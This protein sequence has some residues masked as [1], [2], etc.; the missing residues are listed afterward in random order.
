[1]LKSGFII[2]YSNIKVQPIVALQSEIGFNRNV[3]VLVGF[4]CSVAVFEHRTAVLIQK[5][6]QLR[7]AVIR[8]Q[9]EEMIFGGGIN[10]QRR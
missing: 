4:N 9:G 2:A 8:L 10:S 3:S 1:M 6:L 7:L 5:A